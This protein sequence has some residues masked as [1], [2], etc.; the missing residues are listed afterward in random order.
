MIGA[1]SD[2]V[3]ALVNTIF[4]SFEDLFL[5]LEDIEA[6]FSSPFQI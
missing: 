4:L 6:I 2:K 1:N 5:I 3:R